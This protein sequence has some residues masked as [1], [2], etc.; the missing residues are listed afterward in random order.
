MERKTNTTVSFTTNLVHRTQCIHAQTW[1]LEKKSS[2]CGA[3]N[4]PS[5]QILRIDREGMIDDVICAKMVV[6]SDRCIYLIN[7]SYL[8][9]YIKVEY[10][11]KMTTFGDYP[12][13]VRL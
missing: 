2:Q 8:A 11:K 13:D 12:R 5:P 7:S 10:R 6:D 4:P 3:V 9:S 1:K